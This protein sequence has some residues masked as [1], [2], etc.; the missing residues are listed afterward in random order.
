MGK[1]RTNALI[2]EHNSSGIKY[3]ITTLN[4]EEV[5]IPFLTMSRPLGSKSTAV[6]ADGIT[7]TNLLD[8]LIHRLTTKNLAHPAEKYV[9]AI[10]ALKEAKGFLSE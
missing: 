8:V 5:I 3:S 6:A 10:H 7:E 4:G 2:N 1:D 9:S